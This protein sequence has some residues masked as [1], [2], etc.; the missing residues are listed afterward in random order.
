ML[1]NVRLSALFKEHV[2]VVWIVI[3]IIIIINITVAVCYLCRSPC[4][5]RSKYVATRVLNYGLEFREGLRRF[6]FV[7]F[8]C[9]VDSTRCD[10]LNT[11][12]E[13]P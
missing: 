1:R 5:L 7:M 10:E 9:C 11:R 13:E 3:I 8:L 6:T 2:A 12:L 4:R